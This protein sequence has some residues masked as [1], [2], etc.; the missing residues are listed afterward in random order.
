MKSK[1]PSFRSL[2]SALISRSQTRLVKLE[3]PRKEHNNTEDNKE[4]QRPGKEVK[5]LHLEKNVDDS[6][7][8]S[9]EPSEEISPLVFDNADEVRAQCSSCHH[10]RNPIR[11]A[12]GQEVRKPKA[13]NS[14]APA[15]R[16]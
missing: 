9:N 16:Q 6:I 13:E 15:K 11:Q 5:C 10:G 8:E 7:R 1:S 3:I 4:Q 14:T 2:V 12:E